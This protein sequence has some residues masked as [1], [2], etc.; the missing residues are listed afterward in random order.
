MKLK[1]RLNILITAGP[2]REPIDPVRF[3]SNYSTG[4]LGYEIAKEA[5]KRGHR[6]ILI[7]GP[8][9]LLRPQGVRLID[10]VTARQM[11]KELEKVF[12]WCDCLIMTAAVCDF[13]VKK[14]AK[15]K[16]KRGNKKEIEL[17]LKQN[18][19]ILKSLGGKKGKKML[20]G[21]ALETENLQKNAQD[22]LKEKNLDLI[23]ATQMKINKLPFG[24]K[25]IDVLLAD[26]NGYKQEI[27]AKTKTHLSRVLLER[28]ERAA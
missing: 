5:V 17:K 26:S 4:F 7:S 25:G 24:K 18:P 28:I 10:V 19:D 21:F 3:I 9:S 20:V 27:K 23:V 2:T 8:T 6:V 14:T 11:K 22:K 13:Y 1:K 15:K 12:G 16:I